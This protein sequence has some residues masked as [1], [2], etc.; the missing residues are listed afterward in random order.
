MGAVLA[1][2]MALLLVR[3][4][5]A[6]DWSGPEEL[7][8]QVFILPAVIVTARDGSS[9]AVWTQDDADGR[10]RVFL[11]RITATGRMRPLVPVSDPEQSPAH[12]NVAVDD[13]GDAVVVW[14]APAD[15]P[16][17]WQ[18]FARRVSRTGGLG[19]VVRVSDGAETSTTPS[20]AVTRTGVATIVFDR[21]LQT[22]D[23]YDTVV[24]RFRLDSSLGM[25]TYLPWAYVGAQPVSSRSGHVAFVLSPT[26][27]GRAFV[28]R[29]DPDGD[30]HAR[31]LSA[32]LPGD[33]GI[34]AVDLDRQGNAYAVVS[35]ADGSRAWV[36][37][38]RSNGRLQPA[39]PVTPRGEEVDWVHVRTDLA[40][41]TTVL[42]GDYR[43]SRASYSLRA[44]SW[45][46]D[47][48]GPV[49]RLGRMDGAE[50]PCC[51]ELP[52]WSIDVDDDGDGV[53]AWE[54][55]SPELPDVVIRTRVVRRDG[56]FGRPRDLGTG[57]AP[58]VAV[59]PGGA[60]R[61]TAWSDVQDDTQLLLWTR[62]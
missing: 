59:A 6:A 10:D 46:G 51:A 54:V 8:A 40:G 3:P 15:Y 21:H 35:R 30:V 38:W 50:L 20:V 14:Q 25:P 42:W 17:Q 41:D 5:T 27:D 33:D 26:V 60:A 22:P 53:L 9:T 24:R 62:R 7:A 11:R 45:S 4:A 13:D 52:S 34:A 48:L 43:E 2:L 32:D 57:E 36:R 44:R 55:A 23:D 16:V 28:A 47:R 1:L 31:R 56:S 18:V 49:A 37:V 12:Y 58:V 39:R 61:L 19:P 29:A